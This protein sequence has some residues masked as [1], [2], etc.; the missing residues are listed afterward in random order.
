MYVDCQEIFSGLRISS[1]VA[2]YSFLLFIEWC[3]FRVLLSFSCSNWA[4]LGFT[5]FLCWHRGVCLLFQSVN[6]V[7]FIFLNEYLLILIGEFSIFRVLRMKM[8]MEILLELVLPSFV[9][10]CW[11]FGCYF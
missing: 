3:S 10:S 8:F 4:L 2:T 7:F 11:L 6:G 5:E 9:R 1:G